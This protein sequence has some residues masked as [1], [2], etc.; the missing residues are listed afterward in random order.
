MFDGCV[1]RLCLVGV[2]D[3]CVSFSF[4]KMLKKNVRRKK[5]QNLVRLP[6][7]GTLKAAGSSSSG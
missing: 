4:K 5:H 6:R 1:W 3:G 2:F 7:P